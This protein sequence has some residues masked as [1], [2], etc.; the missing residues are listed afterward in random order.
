MDI[1]AGTVLARAKREGWTQARVGRSKFGTRRRRLAR[2]RTRPRGRPRRLWQRRWQIAG[3]GICS[4]WRASWSAHCL[5][6]RKLGPDALRDRVEDFDRLDKVARRTFGLDNA[7]S[8]FVSVNILTMG[9]LV[10]FEECS[11]AREI[12]ANEVARE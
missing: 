11:D 2:L 8:G 6:S 5:T 12:E 1:P 9:P 10:R 4:A 7:E 3:N